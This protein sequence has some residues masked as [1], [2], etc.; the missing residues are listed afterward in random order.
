MPET[1]LTATQAIQAILAPAIAISAVGLLLLSLITRYSNIINRIRLLNDERRKFSRQLGEKGDLEYTDN[2]RLISVTKQSQELLLRSRY[3]RN[4]ILAMLTAIGSF[5]LSSITIAL[6]LFMSDDLLR[7]IPLVI[8]IIGMICVFIG[9]VF[10]G[11]EVLRSF[12]IV[13]LEVRAEE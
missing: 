1:P 4:A 11:M 12:R 13:L 9:I 2:V 3:I 8:F 5:V 7:A 10:Y 6:N